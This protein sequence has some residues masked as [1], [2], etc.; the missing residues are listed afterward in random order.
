M[1]LVPCISTLARGLSVSVPLQ[2]PAGTGYPTPFCS[3]F[4]A[5][6]AHSISGSH[7]TAPPLHLGCG[8]DLLGIAF[9]PFGTLL[10]RFFQIYPDS[11]SSVSPPQ[12][13][14]SLHSA[15]KCLPPLVLT[16]DGILP[17]ASVI[18][19]TS[20]VPSCFPEA[21]RTWWLSWDIS[22]YLLACNTDLQFSPVCL[23][24]GAGL[25]RAQICWCRAQS[26][27]V[28]LCAP[29]CPQVPV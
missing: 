16:W 3:S 1:N 18:Q 19:K 26:W 25:S 11:S 13:L 6:K 23:L 10:L 2:V 14:I 29:G 4:K 21:F 20:A 7:V 5:T 15:P 27:P 28:W 24:A 8:P 12:H 22:K 17:L 9:K